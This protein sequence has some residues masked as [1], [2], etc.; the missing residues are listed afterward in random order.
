MRGHLSGAGVISGERPG[1]TV[2]G[3]DPLV[4]HVPPRREAGPGQAGRSPAEA[5]RPHEPAR[6]DRTPQRHRRSVRTP[7]VADDGIP[8]AALRVRPAVPGGARRAGAT[9]A[10]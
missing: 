1:R 7:A 4:R 3:T 10:V 8:F 5:E 6:H 9:V 2:E